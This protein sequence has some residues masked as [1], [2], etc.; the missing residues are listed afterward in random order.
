MKKQN[1]LEIISY[2]LFLISLIIFIHN[3]FF[4]SILYMDSISSS[5]SSI[6]SES[7]PLLSNAND[8]STPQ[9]IIP[10]KLTNYDKA[11]R[12]VQW[13]VFAN[14]STMFASYE[15]F[16]NKWDSDFSVTKI[17]YSEFKQLKNNFFNYFKK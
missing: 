16:K 14:K 12:W 11:K 2:Y 1:L 13:N 9:I 6:H 15:D 8:E 10:N 7:A 5:N 17:A 4:E 3:I